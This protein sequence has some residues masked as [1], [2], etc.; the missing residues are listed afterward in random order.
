MNSTENANDPRHYM[1]LTA[2]VAV[3]FAGIF[4]RFAG[5]A[6][7]WSWISNVLLVIGV[8]VALKGVFAIL[9]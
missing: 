7:Y 9:K 8:I 6:P 4:L 2:A 5:E 3:G 1:V